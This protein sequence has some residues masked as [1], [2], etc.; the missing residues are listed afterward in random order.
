ML[1][2]SNIY[3]KQSTIDPPLQTVLVFF[4]S[5]ESIHCFKRLGQKFCL[6]QQ[7]VNSTLEPYERGSS[8]FMILVFNFEK[9]EG[10]SRSSLQ[11]STSAAAQFLP[12]LEENIDKEIQTLTAC[13][14]LL[15]IGGGDSAQNELILDQ[16]QS[17]TRHRVSKKSNQSP[18]IHMCVFR[19][20]LS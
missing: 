9:C 6:L 20:N 3:V 4:N 15:R 1:L 13:S 17:S 8:F 5:V 2:A 12:Q 19:V 7:W 10:K 11:K 18:V 14:V 16:S